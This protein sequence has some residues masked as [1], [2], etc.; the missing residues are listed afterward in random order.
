A[1]RKG[2]GELAVGNIVGADILNVL[3]VVG[4]A[5]AVTAGGLN[6]PISFYKLQI[7]TMLIILIAFR[8]FSRGED[9]QITKKEG[10]FL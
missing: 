5:A 7:P 6:V 3:F 10:T 8:W 2:Q 1:V 9:E 4:S